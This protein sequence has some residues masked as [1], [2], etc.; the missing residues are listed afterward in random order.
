MAII[1]WKSAISDRI[2]ATKRAGRVDPDVIV[3]GKRD[4]ERSAKIGIRI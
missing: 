1:N 3:G 2:L 4:L